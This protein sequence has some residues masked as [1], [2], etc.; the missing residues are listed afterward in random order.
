MIFFFFF[1]FWFH[2]QFCLV[3]SCFVLFCFVLGVHIAKTKLLLCPKSATSLS[4][5]G[6]DMSL[7]GLVVNVSVSK[8]TYPGLISAF[9]V[10][11]FPER[12]TPVTS[13]LALRWPPCQVLGVIGSVVGPVNPFKVGTEVV[14]LPGVWRY[15]VSGGSSQP[16]PLVKS[17]RLALFPFLSL[18]PS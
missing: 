13:K 18:T 5:D 9:T 3:S 8:S 1:F 12:V 15:R 14:T 6:L 17:A 7:V 11:L 4:G 2:D 10:E 16:R